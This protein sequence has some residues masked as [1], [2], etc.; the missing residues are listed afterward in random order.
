M[1]LILTQ[2]KSAGTS[3]RWM[4]SLEPQAGLG[5]A[6]TLN[7]IPPF[8]SVRRVSWFKEAN[9]TPLGTGLTR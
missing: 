8:I 4:Q 1:F 9:N 5:A 6:C 2:I 7:L 3:L